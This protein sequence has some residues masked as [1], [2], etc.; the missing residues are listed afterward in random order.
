MQSAQVVVETERAATVHDVLVRALASTGKLND[1]KPVA[2]FLLRRRYHGDVFALQ[3]PKEFT[4]NW[5]EFVESPPESWVKEIRKLHKDWEHAG[6]RFEPSGAS[7][8]SA[9]SHGEVTAKISST[10]FDYSNGQPRRK[11]GR[12]PKL[13][14]SEPNV[15]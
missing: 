15:E 10:D 8:P 5:M 11:P 9:Q 13:Q 6:S 7:I 3:H 14:L 1:G 4:P 2:G 12:P